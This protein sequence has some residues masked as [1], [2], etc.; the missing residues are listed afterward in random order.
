[1]KR[2]GRGE[3]AIYRT[4]G[5]WWKACANR[6]LT[7]DG[8]RRRLYFSGKTKRE[9]QDRLSAFHAQSVTGT[10]VEP[11][12][13]TIST[14]LNRWL[15]DSVQLSVRPTTLRSYRG[16]VKNHIVPRIGHVVLNQL[17]SQHIQWLY[18][19]LNRSGVA[20]R[21]RELIHSVLRRALEQAV[22]FHQLLK[23]PCDSVDKPRVPKTTMKTFSREQVLAFLSA[24]RGSRLLALYQVA[25]TVGLRQGELLAL[26][27]SDIDLE[28]RCIYVRHTLLEYGGK[29]EL[30]EPKTE[31]SRRRVDLPAFVAA[32]LR[33]HRKRMMAEGHPGPWVF[34]DTSGGP[35]RKSN[36][37]RRDFHPLVEAAGLP[38]I[39]FHDLRHTAAT[40][41]LLAGIH[42][43]VVQETLGHAS[44]SITLD[45]YSHVLPSM[46]LDAAQ[47]ID[48]L[49]SDAENAS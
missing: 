24:A 4:K 14:F 11:S 18:A 29:L 27:W 9:V 33:E 16:I 15:E 31:R 32:G 6:G 3:G 35:L 49:L 38:R 47:R 2:R 21:L 45:L 36:L 7:A 8:K 1:M 13:T 37:T 23:N 12:R 30:G 43:K 19:E 20:P 28:A 44:I 42:P 10:F 26:Q 22:R 34:C 46:Q 48:D 25:V 5:G 40:L 41:M 17:T 39:R